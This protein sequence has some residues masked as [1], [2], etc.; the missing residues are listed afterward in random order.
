MV[1]LWSV[2]PGKVCIYV[3]TNCHIALMMDDQPLAFPIFDITLKVLTYTHNLFLMWVLIVVVDFCAL[4]KRKYYILTGVACNIHHNDDNWWI[5]PLVLVLSC[6]FHCICY[7]R[8]LY[9]FICGNRITNLLLNA[10]FQFSVKGW[11][12]TPGKYSTVSDLLWVI[13]Q[14]YWITF[15]WKYLIKSPIYFLYSENQIKSSTYT[16]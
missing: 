4:V 13:Y 12:S 5:F 8:R 2:Q 14:F 9:K 3:S 15:F 10:L 6:L 7:Q 11:I 16:R 1:V